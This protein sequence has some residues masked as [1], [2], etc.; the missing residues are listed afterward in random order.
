M[1]KEKQCFLPSILS[2]LTFLIQEHK[3]NIL[4]YFKETEEAGKIVKRGKE[5]ALRMQIFLSIFLHFS[6]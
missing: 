3:Q 5:Y 2:L 1:E 4:R 6:S